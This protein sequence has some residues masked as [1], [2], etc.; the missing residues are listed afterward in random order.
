MAMNCAGCKLWAKSEKG[1]PGW[2]MGMGRCSN[3]PKFYAVT[4]DV[5]E[6]DPEDCGDGA[7]T[8]RSEFVGAKALAL[9]GSGHHA[10]LITAPDFGC[11]SFDPR[12]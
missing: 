8:L 5:G 4:E 11:V 6:Y 2:R 1:Q 7:R 12:N 3:V 9:D 10:E